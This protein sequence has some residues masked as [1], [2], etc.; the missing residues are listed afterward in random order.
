MDKHPHIPPCNTRPHSRLEDRDP[1]AWRKSDEGLLDRTPMA[2]MM[3]HPPPPPP[4]GAGPPPMP[5]SRAPT[6][7]SHVYHTPDV[8]G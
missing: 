4:H 8:F 5:H 1:F 7:P 6:P 3:D 2:H